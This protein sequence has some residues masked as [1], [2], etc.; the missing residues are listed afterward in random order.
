MQRSHYTQRY[1]HCAWHLGAVR[2]GTCH[3]ASTVRPSTQGVALLILI[4]ELRESQFSF[5]CFPV[6]RSVGWC[7][8]LLFCLFPFGVFAKARALQGPVSGSSGCWQPS[9]L[10]SITRKMGPPVGGGRLGLGRGRGNGR[11]LSTYPLPPHGS[12]SSKGR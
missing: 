5:F 12:S 4:N 1:V 7:L 9:N 6:T 3:L 2:T 11:K 8:W 10:I